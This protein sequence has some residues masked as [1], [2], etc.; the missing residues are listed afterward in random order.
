MSYPSKYLLLCAAWLAL[1]CAPL[2]GQAQS[3]A[4]ITE[5]NPNDK[6]QAELCASKSGDAREACLREGQDRQIS[7]GVRG[8]E[9]VESTN[10]GYNVARAKCDALSG[11]ARDNCIRRAKTKY[12][13]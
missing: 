3:Q 8:D 4:P 9:R 12:K 10:A 5:P 2:V 11:I 7:A 13:Q 6:L 1:S